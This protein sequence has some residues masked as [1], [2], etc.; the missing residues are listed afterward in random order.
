[1]EILKFKI[2]KNKIITQCPYMCNAFIGKFGVTKKN[3]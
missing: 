3:I 2:K 1:M